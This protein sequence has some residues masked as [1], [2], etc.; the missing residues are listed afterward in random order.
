MDSLLD[1]AAQP[2]QPE[3]LPPADVASAPPPGALFREQKH[4]ST[5]A[6]LFA[7]NPDLY[8]LIVK[9][10]VD[11]RSVKSLADE[12][13]VGRNTIAGVIR[14][15]SSSQSVEQLR[16]DAATHL[17]Y[18]A[19]LARDRAEEALLSGEKIPLQQ[20]AVAGGIFEDK[21]LANEGGPTLNVRVTH[22]VSHADAEAYYER[23]ARTHLDG[24][25]SG[26]REAP[27]A[28]A[29]P[30][31]PAL[32]GPAAASTPGQVRPA[33]AIDVECSEVAAEAVPMVAPDAQS[34]VSEA[35][36]Q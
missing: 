22:E 19:R 27:A 4:E 3:L 2:R 34:D 33:P 8:S 15:E 30:D 1:N 25:S 7:Q 13:H 24:E 5:G 26:Q 32:L 36:P 35:K 14:R 23:L 11:G 31:A 21:A 9:G 17:R 12:Y 6:L 16:R 10:L 29:G 18:L 28:A 20:L